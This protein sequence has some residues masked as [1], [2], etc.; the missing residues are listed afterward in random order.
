[1]QKCKP[2]SVP[3]STCQRH[4]CQDSYHLSGPVVANWIY[5]STRFAGSVEPWASS[6][7][8]IEKQNLF[9]LSTRKVCHAADVAT[10][11]VS[12]YLAISPLPRFFA[13]RHLVRGG[14]ISVALSVPDF[15]K[16]S[17]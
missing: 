4:V 10:G 14:I 1:V 3:W 7:F 2:D 9:D 5:R 16:P 8:S 17:R 6:P 12:S 15:S 13:L 11:T